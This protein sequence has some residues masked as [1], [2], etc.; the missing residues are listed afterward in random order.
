VKKI[1]KITLNKETLLPLRS[2]TRGLR[3]LGAGDA[4]DTG[5]SCDIFR[6]CTIRGWDC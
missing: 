5:P 4:N 2:G 6:A 3:D 1:K